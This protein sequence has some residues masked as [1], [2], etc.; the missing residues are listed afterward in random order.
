MP[1]PPAAMPSAHS[2][3]GHT[4]VPGAAAADRCS[5]ERYW[6]RMTGALSLQKYAGDVTRR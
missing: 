6:R 4:G 3:P 5:Q 2:H 1:I